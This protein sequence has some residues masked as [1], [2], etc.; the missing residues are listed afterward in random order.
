M[1]GPTDCAQ[2]LTSA[3][4]I[5]VLTGPASSVAGP[6]NSA[7]H[8]TPAADA[9]GPGRTG[10]ADFNRLGRPWYQPQLE[11][12]VWGRFGV[13]Q[14]S[15][16]ERGADSDASWT[17]DGY[18]SSPWRSCAWEQPWE[19]LQSGAPG[20]IA[21]AGYGQPTTLPSRRPAVHLG[22][23]NARFTRR[24]G[25]L[26]GPPTGGRVEVLRRPRPRPRP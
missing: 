17:P 12:T 7:E 14:R 22:G 3:N 10:S 20:T 19:H 9:G 21:G 25:A 24:G 5:W 18:G 2:V 1:R 4:Q 15:H 6:N 11:H 8:H 26:R 23:P 16:S 13:L